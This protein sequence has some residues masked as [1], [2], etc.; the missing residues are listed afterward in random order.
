MKIQTPCPTPWAK[1]AVAT[2][3]KW[4]RTG[5]I[6]PSKAHMED[7]SQII[8]AFIIIAIQDLLNMHEHRVLEHMQC[9]L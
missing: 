2:I 3:T 6:D 7:V 8:S 1:E 9:L 4:S 5:A